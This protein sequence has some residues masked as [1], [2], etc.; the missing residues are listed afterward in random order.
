MTPETVYVVLKHASA[1]A[2]D[3]VGG[4]SSYSAEN[5]TKQAVAKLP[6]DQQDGTYVAVP[7]RNWRPVNLTAKVETTLVLAEVQP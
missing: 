4:A 5:A 1:M 3:F 2:W 6:A 7:A